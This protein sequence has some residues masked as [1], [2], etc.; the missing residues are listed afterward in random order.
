MLHTCV[1][2]I[3]YKDWN[4]LCSVYYY[5]F[6]HL[7]LNFEAQS[8][9]DNCEKW[10]ESMGVIQSIIIRESVDST[11]RNVIHYKG[12]KISGIF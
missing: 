4:I 2:V 1:T 5:A 9:D 7:H 10:V 6:K 8:M 12:Q 11:S 3:H